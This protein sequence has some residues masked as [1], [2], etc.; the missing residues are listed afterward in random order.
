MELNSRYA[1]AA[2]QIEQSILYDYCV[3]TER[4]FKYEPNDL[5]EYKKTVD[6]IIYS[7]AND[8]LI[9]YNFTPPSFIY[10]LDDATLEQYQVK[11]PDEV[12]IYHV[13]HPDQHWSK[14][15]FSGC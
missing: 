12:W 9:H 7:G 6:G 5:D 2:S 10:Q 14:H 3:Q 15:L 11:I 13:Q 8:T 1:R 4:S